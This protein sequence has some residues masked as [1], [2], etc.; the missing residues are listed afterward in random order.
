MD[1]FSFKRVLQ[2]VLSVV[3]FYPTVASV[4]DTCGI[5]LQKTGAIP[6]TQ[7]C[8]AVCSSSMVNLGTYGCPTRCPEFCGKGRKTCDT[9]VKEL[10][11]LPL[12]KGDPTNLFVINQTCIAD[13]ACKNKS[14]M[15]NPKW[16]DNVVNDFVGAFLKK[17]GRWKAK[18]KECLS[19][20][21]PLIVK[22]ALC[23]GKMA[24]YHI[25][26]DLRN[27]VNRYG[28]G[29]NNDWNRIGRY[30]SRCL[31]NVNGSRNLMINVFAE[32]VVPMYR[33]TVRSECL[34][35]RRENNLN[36]YVN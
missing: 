7:Q 2:V 21:G 13:T 1:R 32:I 34:L 4:A 27:A 20:E 5:W 17:A 33:K 31:L 19:Y 22:E 11:K 18:I 36:P 16:L 28:C 29:T 3:C 8:M 14:K 12:S 25:H 26:T 24:E 10:Q 15:D 35:Y 30:I 23:A 9:V 6:G